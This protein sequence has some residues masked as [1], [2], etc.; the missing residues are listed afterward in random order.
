MYRKKPTAQN[1]E[2]Q[3]MRLYRPED[4]QVAA[5][6]SHCVCPAG[7]KPYSNGSGCT[8][9]GRQCHK[10]TSSQ[11][12]CG[13]CEPRHRCLRHPA[14]TA[15]RQVAIFKIEQRIPSG[16]LQAMKQRID[17]PEGRRLAGCDLKK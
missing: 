3:K 7:R 14:R 17:S 4:F 1:Q 8:I 2:D 10:Y 15:V 5:G 13:S 16:V 6:E 11:T 9:N 12:G